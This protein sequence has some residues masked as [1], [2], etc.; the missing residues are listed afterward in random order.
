MQTKRMAEIVLASRRRSRI[1]ITS[2]GIEAQ[3]MYRTSSF[4]CRSDRFIANLEKTRHKIRKRNILIE[5][6]S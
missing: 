4:P 2:E 6:G 1:A 5:A 3:G